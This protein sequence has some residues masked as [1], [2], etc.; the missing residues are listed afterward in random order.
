[1]KQ[2]E[3]ERHDEPD[4]DQRVKREM[5][6]IEGRLR[7]DAS[8]KALIAPQDRGVDRARPPR[9]PQRS[10]QEPP[11]CRRAAGAAAVQPCG[12]RSDSAP[13]RPAPRRTAPSRG[14]RAAPSGDRGGA[15]GAVANQKSARAATSAAT[16]AAVVMM[17]VRRSRVRRRTSMRVPAHSRIVTAQI[18]RMAA[19]V[20]RRQ[21]R[22][23]AARSAGATSPTTSSWP[24]LEGMT[25]V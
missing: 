7:H 12:V 23:A 13:S 18:D 9:T 11:G 10:P 17:T 1:M 24:P 20:P 5:Q 22:F 25:K 15:A 2:H 8:E 6:E 3:P 19:R 21:S 16:I 4:R 14:D